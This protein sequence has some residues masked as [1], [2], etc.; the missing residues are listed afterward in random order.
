[1]EESI[2]ILKSLRKRIDEAFRVLKIYKKEEELKRLEHETLSPGFW[3]KDDASQIMKKIGSLKNF[4]QNWKQIRIDVDEYLGLSEMVKVS[5]RELVADIHDNTLKLQSE[6]DKM[7]FQM[8]LSDEYDENDAILSIFA[9]AG[10]TEAQDWA[11]MLL[12]MYKRFADSHEFATKIT[13]ISSGEEAGIKSVTLEVS[14][15]FAYGYLK[16]EAGVHRLV[17]IS[18]FDAD[19]ARHTS[20][21]LVDVL[22]EFVE[23]EFKINETDLRIDTF[24]AGGHGGQGVNTTDSAVRITHLPTGLS[25]SVQNERSQL[26]NKQTALKIL[27]SKL[28]ILEKKKHKEKMTEIRGEAIS[29]EWG[30]QIRSYVMQPY[31]KVKDHRTEYETS[32]VNLVLD[33]GID[34]FIEAYLKKET[35]KKH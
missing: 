10:G 21:A 33:G 11:E 13:S 2:E 27:Q 20:F 26:Q 1:M 19:K 29:A 24:R 16:G 30:N 28:A 17:R 32:N 25:V 14:G 4:I 34:E 15:P 35:L 23:P 12:R 3:E 7:E 9:G 18:P 22:P 31:T 8:L 6:F 5:D